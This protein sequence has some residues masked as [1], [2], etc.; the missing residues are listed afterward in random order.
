MN[1]FTYAWY[2]KLI[3][4]ICKNGYTITNYHDYVNV[5]K[6]CILRHDIDMDIEKAAEFAANEHRF[7][8]RF[9]N[10][11]KT[12]TYFILLTSDFY[13]IFT[14]KSLKSIDKILSFGNEIGLHFDET[15][16][17]YNNDINTFAKYA[18]EECYLLG[19]MLGIEIRTISMH[20][21]SKFAIESNFTFTNMINSY[22]KEFFD[23]F[24][25]LSDS[26]MN[27][28]ENPFEA[29]NSNKWDK[30][31]IL[32]HPFWYSDISES[33]KNKLL[34]FINQAE[35]QRYWNISDNFRD[36]NE[37]VNLEEL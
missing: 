26:R 8:D 10:G 12:S 3:D 30:L 31:H 15:K 9:D 5:D 24:K 37:L 29:I 1:E 13:N 14:K 6:P 28:R 33:T 17:S 20:R 4:S 16:Y 7:L 2:D 27:W 36:L 21:P 23:S 25:Y 19:R 32:T 18:E 11:C 34:S 35:I 22:S